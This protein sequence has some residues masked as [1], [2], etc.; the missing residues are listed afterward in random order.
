M[1]T[2]RNMLYSTTIIV[3]N[4][5]LV[6][7]NYQNPSYLHFKHLKYNTLYDAEKTDRFEH[8][9]CTLLNYLVVRKGSVFAQEKLCF[10]AILVLN[11]FKFM[12]ALVHHLVQHLDG[13]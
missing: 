7:Q 6:F 8:I 2:G 11:V 10:V 1:V 5:D 3:S 9:L 12:A 4:P 13:R